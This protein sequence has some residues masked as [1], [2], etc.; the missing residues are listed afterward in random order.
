M[1]SRMIQS[2]NYRKL[3]LFLA[4]V[5]FPFF[6]SASQPVES[7]EKPSEE[8]KDHSG[9]SFEI[10]SDGKLIYKIYDPAYQPA[11]VRTS[12]PAHALSEAKALIEIY[13]YDQ[14]I[15]ILQSLYYIPLSVSNPT[16]LQLETQTEAKKILELHRSSSGAFRM[17]LKKNRE[18][19]LPVFVFN[20]ESGRFYLYHENPPFQLL[21]P[22]AWTPYVLPRFN[23]GEKRIILRHKDRLVDLTIQSYNQYRPVPPSSLENEV[24]RG[25]DLRM[26]LTETGKRAIGYTIEKLD[27]KALPPCPKGA[28]CSFFVSRFQFPRKKA[29][30]Y[31]EFRIRRPDGAVFLLFPAGK[32]QKE[33]A[34]LNQYIFVLQNS[35]F[36]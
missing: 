21:F 15:E 31:Y 6:S 7:L 9:R 20:D 11:V 19:G 36:Y 2:A 12:A 25:E 8:F 24:R 4:S 22:G 30:S 5:L 10:T 1:G 18:L 35:R 32:T 28:L 23:Q 27:R 3:F 16:A 34:T 33:K 13:A 17:A 26:G 29:A 14:A